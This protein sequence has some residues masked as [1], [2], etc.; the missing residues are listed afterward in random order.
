M[1]VVVVVA[2]SATTI[3]FAVPITFAVAIAVAVPVAPANHRRSHPNGSGRAP[4]SFKRW[5]DANDAKLLEAQSDDDA[6]S[7]AGNDDGIMGDSEGI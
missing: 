6:Y 2:A 1:V 7:A 3:A 4:P 5:T